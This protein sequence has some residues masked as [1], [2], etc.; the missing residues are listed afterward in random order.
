MWPKKL[1]NSQLHC[2]T[3]QPRLRSHSSP[4]QQQWVLCAD[5]QSFGSAFLMDFSFH[6]N[7]LSL[8]DPK[9]KKELECLQGSCSNSSL[10]SF[11]FPLSAPTALPA[12]Q[13]TEGCSESSAAPTPRAA[14]EAVPCNA[15]LCLADEEL[16]SPQVLGGFLLSFQQQAEQGE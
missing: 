5:A 13:H 7:K 4:D 1:L 3:L 12:E 11:N 16:S 8:G 15:W 2:C 6:L 14:P 10:L 9:E